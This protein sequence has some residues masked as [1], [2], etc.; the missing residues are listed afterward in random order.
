MNLIPIP[1][2]KWL[3]YSRIG[4][5]IV[6]KMRIKQSQ[7]HFNI[8]NG[9]KIFL[10]FTNPL[11]W[12][13]ILKKDVE[14][15]I[16]KVFLNNISP[17]DIVVDVGAHIG[18]YSIIGSKKIGTSGQVIC[19]EPLSYAIK[20]LKQNSQL[21]N[22]ST[23][24]IIEC[25]VGSKNGVSQLYQNSSGGTFGYLLRTRRGG[26]RGGGRPND[27]GRASA[28]GRD[29]RNQQG[30]GG[31]EGYALGGRPSERVRIPQIQGWPP[32]V[33]AN[34]GGHHGRQE[35]FGVLSGK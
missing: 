18:E 9:V 17:G 31:S 29:D 30:G 14:K 10:D 20:W 5:S 22:F 28:H 8:D 16:K 27:W 6:S 26:I 15:N 1:F 3:G 4:S 33:Y 2:L 13:L 32:P 24:E 21:N 25:A 23:Y 7:D 35:G 19:I 34:T 11:T 12:E